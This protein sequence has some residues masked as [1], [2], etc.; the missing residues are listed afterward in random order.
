MDFIKKECS[1]N[2]ICIKN[3]ECHCKNECNCGHRRHEGYCLSKECSCKLQ[4]CRN[5]DK[6]QIKLPQW[7]L[8]CHDGLCDKCIVQMGNHK[9]TNINQECPIC[10][11]DER[12][13]ELQ[14]GHYLC[15]ECWYSITFDILSKDITEEYVECPICRNKN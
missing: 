8:D 14:C 1:G 7:I 12:M 15:N 3:C 2:G 6:C 4:D 5:I 11:E 10:L 9:I 13:I